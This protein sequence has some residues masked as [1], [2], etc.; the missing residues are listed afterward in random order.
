M[1]PGG[2][3][4]LSSAGTCCRFLLF[5]ADRGGIEG[6]GCG[7]RPSSDPDVNSHTSQL[8]LVAP[9]RYS[10]RLWQEG[11][12]SGVQTGISNMNRFKCTQE[13]LFPGWKKT[14][15]LFTANQ[16]CW[17][18]FFSVAQKIKNAACCCLCWRR[19]QQTPWRSSYA[20]GPSYTGTK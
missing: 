7:P 12:R 8:S 13:V 16:A 1:R 2:Q 14:P 20:A 5:D 9:R 11:E 4:N 6:R 19:F 3:T 10:K 18:V 15:W 17:S